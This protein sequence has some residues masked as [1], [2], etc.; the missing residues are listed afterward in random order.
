MLLRFLY[1]APLPAIQCVVLCL[2]RAV[3]VLRRAS[4]C[5]RPRVP[6]ATYAARPL[7]RPLAS[8]AQTRCCRVFA[9]V[10]VCTLY[11]LLCLQRVLSCSAPS[12]VFSHSI[13][14][15]AFAVRRLAIFARKASKSTTTALFAL[16]IR[17]SRCNSRSNNLCKF[18]V[19]RDCNFPQL[20]LPAAIWR[21][22]RVEQQCAAAEQQAREW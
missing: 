6:I 9:A 14:A 5:L 20:K 18:V 4:L 17:A 13:L 12:A 21:P 15:S 3:C 22:V 16:L 1:R 2:I 10:R 8:I 7:G 19:L 11:L